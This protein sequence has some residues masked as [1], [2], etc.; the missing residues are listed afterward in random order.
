MY[1]IRSYYDMIGN[2]VHHHIHR[3]AV[4]AD[5]FGAGTTD[6][7]KTAAANHFHLNAAR[8]DQN[9]PGTDTVTVFRFSDFH[10]AKLIQAVRKHFGKTGWHMLHDDDAGRVGG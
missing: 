5:F 10:L 7:V 1:A 4:T 3:R 9:Q 8:R 2:R 6:L